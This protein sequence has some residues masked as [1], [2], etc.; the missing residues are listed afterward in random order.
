MHN[1]VVSF[2]AVTY[3]AANVYAIVKVG[4]FEVARSRKHL[5]LYGVPFILWGSVILLGCWLMEIM[6]RFDEW[7]PAARIRVDNVLRF[8]ANSFGALSAQ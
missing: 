2:L 3:L 8:S 7:A 1:L 4:G 5:I 6:R